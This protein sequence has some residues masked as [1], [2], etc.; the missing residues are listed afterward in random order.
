MSISP[1]PFTLQPH[2][3]PLAVL[4]MHTP[5]AS[6]P[7]MAWALVE[8]KRAMAKMIIARKV[9]VEQNAARDFVASMVAPHI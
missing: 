6:L 2:R 3:A 1:F 5:T 8:E 7:V 4:S 9:L